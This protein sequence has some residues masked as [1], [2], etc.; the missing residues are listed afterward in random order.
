[1]FRNY[2]WENVDEMW[3]RRILMVAKH[4]CISGH[5]PKWPFKTVDFYMS[6]QL[7]YILLLWHYTVSK[8]MDSSSVTSLI[9]TGQPS[10]AGGNLS[11]PFPPSLS[12]SPA[13]FSVPSLPPC[14]WFTSASAPEYL[15]YWPLNADVPRRKI[16]EQYGWN[17]EEPIFTMQGIP[18]WKIASFVAESLI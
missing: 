7:Y 11:L 5:N 10:L 8:S 18:I 13:F 15:D 6:F 4:F 9:F 1:M 17:W 12:H 3:I 2:Q 14:C 16:V